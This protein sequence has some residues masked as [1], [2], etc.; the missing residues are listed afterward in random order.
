VP[1]KDL[2]IVRLGLTPEQDLRTGAIG[3][4]MGRVARAFPNV[5]AQV[6]P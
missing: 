2:I 3:A 4:W 6:E 5:N 1:S